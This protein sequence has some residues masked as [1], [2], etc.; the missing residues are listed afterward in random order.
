[1]LSALSIMAPATIPKARSHASAYVDRQA[2]PATSA[3]APISALPTTGYC[4]GHGAVCDVPR[5]KVAELG[6]DRPEIP[7]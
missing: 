4:T 2:L 5:T 6:D 7:Q 3:I 1:V